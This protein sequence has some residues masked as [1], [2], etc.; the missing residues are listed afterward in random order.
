MIEL[1]LENQNNSQ[2]CTD[3]KSVSI[4]QSIY[5]S[6]S[7]P[8]RLNI[9]HCVINLLMKMVQSGRSKS[10][11]FEKLFQIICIYV[12]DQAAEDR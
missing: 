2:F 1:I 9:A 4:L 8:V 3:S 6:K 7:I 12:V 11:E 10:P 5:Q